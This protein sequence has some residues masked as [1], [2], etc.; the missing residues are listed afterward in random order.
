MLRLILSYILFISAMGAS[1]A[2]ASEPPSA[3]AWKG[4]LKLP[5]GKALNLV[6]NLTKT[7]EGAPQFTLDSPDQGAYGIPGE[8]IYYSPDSINVTVKSIGMSYAGKCSDGREMSGVFRQGLASL[9]LTLERSEAA[10]PKRP[11]TP[12]PPFPYT[13]NEVTFPGGAADVTLAA[14]LTI[15]D[16][17]T[18]GSPAVIMVTGSGLQNRDEEAFGHKPFA[19]I[20][21]Y[22]ARNGIASLRYDDRG[23][24]KSTGNAA[25][26]TTA[27]NAADAVA[28]LKYL[29]DTGAFGRIGVLGHSEGGLVAL[30]LGADSLASPDFIIGL[31]APAVRGDSILARQ[32]ADALRAEGIPA[33]I[34][35]EYTGSLIKLYEYLARNGRPDNAQKLIN[36][37]WPEQQ[38]GADLIRTALARNLSLIASKANPWTVYYSALSPAPYLGSLTCPALLIYGDKDIQVPADMNAPVAQHVAPDATVRVYPG[39]NHLMQHASSGA[40]SEYASIEET[41]SYEVLQAIADFITSGK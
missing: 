8:V 39:L 7:P 12:V 2:V 30:M 37:I 26:I 25:E 24:G 15:P 1:S 33:N 35:S 5:G 10:T 31:A 6:F 41:I 14:T 27:D 23:F 17:P 36:D 38:S 29:R 18:E 40:V 11:Q 3:E 21:D 4:T 19:V 13:S 22:L 20:A 32:S 16:K 28:A 9:P 34:I